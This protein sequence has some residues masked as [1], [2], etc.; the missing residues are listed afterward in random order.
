MSN[1]YGRLLRR[2][3]K[4]RALDA[5]TAEMLIEKNAEDGGPGSGNFGHKGR[6]GKRG[7]S[8]KRGAGGGGLSKE[9]HARI[10]KLKADFPNRSTEEIERAR[11]SAVRDLVK[12]RGIVESYKT[13]GLHNNPSF[14]E[15]YDYHVSQVEPLKAYVEAF[16]EEL[17]RRKGPSQPKISD[18]TRGDMESTISTLKSKI[19]PNDARAREITKEIEWVNQAKNRE[20]FIDRGR[21]ILAFYRDE[22]G[23]VKYIRDPKSK[24][25]C[26]TAMKE[27]ESSVFSE[28]DDAQRELKESLG[29]DIEG[30]NTPPE[31]TD[32]Y[33]KLMHGIAQAYKE[34]GPDYTGERGDLMRLWNDTVARAERAGIPHSELAEIWKKPDL[35]MARSASDPLFEKIL[36]GEGYKGERSDISAQTRKKLED[37]TKSKREAASKFHKGLPYSPQTREERLLNDVLDDVEWL[38][39]AQHSRDWFMEQ[40]KSYVDFLEGQMEEYKKAGV[41][42][43]LLHHMSDIKNQISL[44]VFQEELDRREEDRRYNYRREPEETGR[45]E[46]EITGADPVVQ[47]KKLRDANMIQADKCFEQASQYEEGSEERNILERYADILSKPLSGRPTKQQSRELTKKFLGNISKQLKPYAVKRY[48]K[49]LK[50]EP[51]ITSDLCDI[52]EMLGTSMYGLDYRLKK[53]SDSSDGGCRIAEKIQENM[54]DARK[55]GDDDSYEAAVD[56]LSDMVRYTQACTRENFTRNFEATKS[57]LESKGYKPIK[58]KNTWNTYSEKRPYR[59]INCVFMSPTGT[60]FELQFHT[61]ESLVAKELQHPWYEEVR[62]TTNPPPANRKADLEKRMYK[63]MATLSAPDGIENIKSFP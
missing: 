26:E 50:N 55:N 10:A 16:T 21:A 60:R 7:G 14:K 63:N 29:P 30:A 8:A 33:R 52:A 12:E 39:D 54:D 47:K 38:T 9:Q 49:D 59:G 19:N 23:E 36:N 28:H 32:H 44:A 58:V 6:P 57:Y 46:P 45:P 25:A 51:Q 5:E 31:V 61:P 17:E 15:R 4:D 40:G 34:Y 1:V 62:N 2:L 20:E 56:S 18:M 42:Q 48:K 13:S 22:S 37:L 24:E 35:D 41:D 27:L 43:K 53:A 11:R 3:A